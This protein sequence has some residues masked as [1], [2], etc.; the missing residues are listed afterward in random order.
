MSNTIEMEVLAGKPLLDAT[1]R[2]HKVSENNSIVIPNFMH[3]LTYVRESLRPKLSHSSA[4]CSS[5]PDEI[6]EV[7]KYFSDWKES[8]KGLIFRHGSTLTEVELKETTLLSN[9]FRREHIQ[10][11]KHF[12]RGVKTS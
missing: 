4:V 7:C 8:S 9:F 6:E 10:M 3:H 1:R 11:P 5:K 2:Y 12:T